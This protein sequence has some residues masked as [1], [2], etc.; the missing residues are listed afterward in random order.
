MSPAEE[1]DAYE[2]PPVRMRNLYKRYQKC[3]MKDVDV[4]ANIIDTDEAL[5]EFGDQLRHH[6]ASYI[7]DRDSAFQAFLS[8]PADERCE[9]S[10][11]A[12]EVMNIPGQLIC[13]SY[14][15]VL[16]IQD[17]ISCLVC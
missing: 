5:N 11:P 14:Y 12:F 10:T 15:L 16:R 2:R 1:L 17:S 4:D 6:P 9:V 8:G 3:E 7:G 13:S